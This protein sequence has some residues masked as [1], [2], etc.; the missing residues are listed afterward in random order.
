MPNELN[1]PSRR[2]VLRAAALGGAGVLLQPMSIVLA[3][4]TGADIVTGEEG[5]VGP[6]T[7][8]TTLACTTNLV[9]HNEIWDQLT[10]YEPT[11]AA[12][13]FRYNPTFYSRCET[14]LYF[15]YVNTPLSWL[16]PLRIWT[17]GVYAYR[18]DGCVSMHNYGRAFDLTRIYAT[19]NGVNTKVFNGRYDQWRTWTGSSLTT[20]RKRYWATA[21]SL[22]YHFKYVLT[23]FY[24]SAHWNHI[25]F[26]NQVSGSGNST[27]S[28]GSKSQ[29]QHVQACCTYIWGYPTTIDGIWGPQTSGNSSKVLARIGRSGSLTSSQTNWLEFNKASLRFG[30][31]RQ[32]Y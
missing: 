30:S 10:Y 5:A 2:T 11:G 21:A 29:V 7:G 12:S 9:S 19:V 27:F 15:W 25:H 28:T 4:E 1:R 31:G 3:E 13:S 22:H 16:T 26:D 24:N 20:V 8:D 23:Y 32:S 17:Y 6:D 14:W 18:N